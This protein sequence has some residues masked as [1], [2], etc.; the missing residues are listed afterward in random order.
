MTTAHASETPSYE[1]P[2]RPF[3]ANGEPRKVGI[4]VE[5]ANLSLPE[6]MDI[7]ASVLGG[8]PEAES[9]TQG[10][11]KDTR[12]GTF[13]VEFDS[14]AL[15]DRAYLR[16]FAKL[17]LDAESTAAHLVEETVLT[18]AKEFVPIEV[19][20]PPIPWNRLGETDPL[21]RALRREG[22]EDTHDSVFYA[23]GLHLNPEL[24]S[25]DVHTVLDYFRGFLLLEDWMQEATDMDLSR[26]LSPYVKTFPDDYKARV[27]ALDYA[28]DW[29]A[30]IDDYVTYN[31][32]RNRTLDLL[33][34]FR[35]VTD[36]DLSGRIETWELVNARPTFHYRMP[37]CELAD[38]RWSPAVEWNRWLLT[39]RLAENKALLAMM[40]REYLERTTSS[41]AEPWTKHL[42]T[43][44][45]SLDGHVHHAS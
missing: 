42:R 1:A 2:P 6:A 13:K 10:A 3:A 27:L 33:P 22:A 38:P 31:P 16:P 30:F 4:E 9:L 43:R 44:L 36:L 7:I 21:W 35:S 28:P 14:K 34:L 17:G 19:V 15:K 23:F 8:T 45:A 26:K 39:E 18:V 12:L 20:S 29:P 40:C 41:S 37:N 24:P 11:V 25:T 32:T 5:L